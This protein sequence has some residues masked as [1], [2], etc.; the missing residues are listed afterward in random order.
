VTPPRGTY[1]F[2]VTGDF[3]PPAGPDCGCS[4]YDFA[5]RQVT[6][7]GISNPDEINLTDGWPIGG[8]YMYGSTYNLDLTGSPYINPTPHGGTYELVAFNLNTMLE[9]PV[10][11]PFVVPAKVSTQLNTQSSVTSTIQGAL[12]HFSLV[13]S[14]VWTD[15]VTTQDPPSGSSYTLQ[16]QGTGTA[17]WVSIK[18]DYKPTFDLNVTGPGNYRILSDSH[19]STEVYV[20]VHVP[21]VARSIANAIVSPSQAIVGASLVVSSQITTQYDDTNWYPSPAGTAYAIDWLPTG[22]SVWTSIGGGTVTIPGVI[23][24]HVLMPGTGLLR[25][26]SGD[27]IGDALP[28]TA[29]VPTSV[30]SVTALTLPTTVLTN[31]PFT[32]GTSASTRYS[33][34]MY[35]ATPVGTK[36]EVYFASAT[37]PKKSVTALRWTRVIAARTTLKG[38]IIAKVRTRSSGYWRIVVVSK[39]TR[40]AYVRVRTK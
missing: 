10:A 9:E 35:R 31:T 36:Y 23:A 33:D 39:S 37:A 5:L 34:G 2:E 4:F 18:N 38:K 40:A 11:G 8:L 21:T 30:I 28:L 26:T 14:V 25:I 7:P 12:V 27:A 29:I 16:Y 3:T 22:G 20:D 17:N 6:G 32:L 13:D 19:V 15:G 1:N 24:T